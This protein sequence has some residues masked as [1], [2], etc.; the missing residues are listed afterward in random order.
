MDDDFFDESIAVSEMLGDN[1]LFVCSPGTA[2]L[3]SDEAESRGTI[4]IRVLCNDLFYWACADCEELPFNQIQPLYEEWIKDKRWGSSI[5][6][7]RRRNLRPQVPI[8]E[9]M[10]KA[11]VWTEELE[12]LPSP[13]PS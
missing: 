13:H 6:C 9:D 1:T 5:W 2:F 7:C 4:E 12:K 10:K 3:T 8:V 11:G